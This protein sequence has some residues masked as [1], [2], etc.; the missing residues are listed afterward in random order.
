MPTLQPTSITLVSM[1]EATLPELGRG[2]LYRARLAA[3][4]PS[5]S[6]ADCAA[7]WP[8]GAALL[9]AGFCCC[10]WEASW[11]L[12]L[13]AL[14]LGPPLSSAGGAEGGV[15][16]RRCRSAAAAPC[17]LARWSPRA[18][19]S[20]SASGCCCCC[21]CCAPAA[22][23]SA[24]LSASWL[25]ATAAASP[26]VERRPLLCA[27]QGTCARGVPPATGVPAACC[28]LPA[29]EW[30]SSAHTTGSWR[31]HRSCASPSL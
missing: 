24:W 1:G 31:R 22:L 28:S 10:C 25:A 21:C 5:A 12:P 18:A 20:L 11:L 15:R 14:G 27:E 30:S 9:G 19:V 4:S 2:L 3:R 26:G 6:S 7:P 17:C 29:R 23:C 16:P 8:F 13:A